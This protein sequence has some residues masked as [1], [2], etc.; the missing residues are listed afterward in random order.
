MACSSPTL[1]ATLVA[2]LA[3]LSLAAAASPPP[4]KVALH[5]G[6]QT[7]QVEV[8]RTPAQRELGLM[9]RSRLDDDAGMLFVFENKARHCFWMKNT[10]IPLSIA[11]LADDGRIVNIAD[12]QPQAL[13]LH[14]SRVPVRHA[15]EVMQGG[16]SRNGIKAGMRITG[17]PFGPARD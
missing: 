5:A 1:R 2:L 8:A 14:C 3:T 13:D 16:F 15:L 9:E 10:L 11:F 7:F 6:A 17:G 4:P 12:M